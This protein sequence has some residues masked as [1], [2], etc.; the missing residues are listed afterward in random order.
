MF[1]IQQPS[2]FIIIF[3]NT[4]AAT[5]PASA[6]GSAC[7]DNM[8]SPEP[9]AHHQSANTTRQAPSS[10][11]AQHLVT[12]YSNVLML[13]SSCCICC[14]ARVQHA[15]T[16]TYPGT[17]TKVYCLHFTCVLSSA[18]TENST[19]ENTCVKVCCLHP[20]VCNYPNQTGV[21]TR[22]RNPAWHSALP[23]A[24][25]S[26][27]LQRESNGLRHTADATQRPV[28]TTATQD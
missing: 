24:I 11:T 25:A 19:T 16:G 10:A 12:A 6:C 20:H 7:A 9:P 23:H 5:T 15:G 14:D 3:G 22:I 27:R 2:V 21:Q 26:R 28:K 17:V 4:V 8:C 1:T 18:T 13:K